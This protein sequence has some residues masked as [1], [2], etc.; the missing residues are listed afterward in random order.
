[1]IDQAEK[2]EHSLQELEQHLRNLANCASLHLNIISLPR[3]RASILAADTS[4]AI[5]SKVGC[6]RAAKARLTEAYREAECKIDAH[7]QLS[8]S[9]SFYSDFKQY[10]DRQLEVIQEHLEA[11]YT[12]ETAAVIEKISTYLPESTIQAKAKQII[13]SLAKE[14]RLPGIERYYSRI[15]YDVWDPSD[16]EEGLAKLF[17]KAFKRYGFDCFD[18]IRAIEEDAENVLETAR[19]KFNAEIRQEMISGSSVECVG[20]R[21]AENQP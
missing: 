13:D 1:M 12:P 2:I 3:D 5:T 18:A 10:F 16:F 8:G 7:W 14:Y 6:H 9:K 4:E 11:L 17:A 15:C 21:F 19:E 20:G